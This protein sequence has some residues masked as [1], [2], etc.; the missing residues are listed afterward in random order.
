MA[1]LRQL[2]L[3]HLGLRAVKRPLVWGGGAGGGVSV[4]LMETLIATSLAF[5]LSLSCSGSSCLDRDC[6]EETDVLIFHG[7]H[8]PLVCCL[9]SQVYPPHPH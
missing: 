4:R 9:A 8:V 2:L 7:G 5:C 6:R 1:D 3:L